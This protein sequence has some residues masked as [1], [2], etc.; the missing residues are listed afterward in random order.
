MSISYRYD[1]FQLAKAVP[2]SYHG[3][4]LDPDTYIF[5][6]NLTATRRPDPLAGRR[7]APEECRSAVRGLGLLNWDGIP[8]Q[9][10]A[11]GGQADLG[12]PDAFVSVVVAE[13]TGAVADRF[14]AQLPD[15]DP[16]CASIRFDDSNDRA[17]VSK[18]SLPGLGDRSTYLVRS[19]P[20]AGKPWTERIL[21]YRTPRYVVET[22]LYAPSGPEADFLVF[23]RQAWDLAAAKLT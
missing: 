7:I 10:P 12:G 20:R 4:D 17:S 6:P 18:R 1:V 13:A 8:S 14:M 19:Y 9:T 21:L 5:F 3:H 11:A 15:I 16:A 22:V 23:S 2:T